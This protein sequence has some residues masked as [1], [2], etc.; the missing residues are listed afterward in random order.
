MIHRQHYGILTINA[1]TCS[2][3]VVIP[4]Q[5]DIFSIQ[6]LSN[7]Q[8]QINAVKEYTNPNLK[9]KGV[10]LTKYQDRTILNRKLYYTIEN[11]TK[12]IN[13]SLFKATIREG[14]AIRESQ[15][16]QSNIFD[17]DPKGK[18]TKDYTDFIN[19]F[20]KQK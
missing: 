7:L 12:Q 15:T 20:L 9:V 3:S 11:A 2:D 4:M 14:V 17:Y 8:K 1:L 6:G 5:A 16:K 19:E 13:I 10:L 18:V